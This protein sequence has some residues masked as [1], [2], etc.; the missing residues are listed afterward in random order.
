MKKLDILKKANFNNEFD[1]ALLIELTKDQKSDG[2]Y[3]RG[4]RN[5]YPSGGKTW[6]Y[7]YEGYHIRQF[8]TVE[9]LVKWFNNSH[10]TK[11]DN[12]YVSKEFEL[13]EKEAEE[14]DEWIECEK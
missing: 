3:F 10:N 9:D 2:H 11:A 7:N 14:E 6:E 8:R 12:L 1:E 5:I 4:S 13:A